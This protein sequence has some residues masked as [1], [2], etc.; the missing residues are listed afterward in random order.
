MPLISCKINLTLT[1]SANCLIID[2]LIANQM[3]TFIITDEN[4]YV[5]TVTLSTQDNTNL[6]QQLRWNI[7]LNC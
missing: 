7:K 4:L 5:P 1:W 3:L 6:L 2:A